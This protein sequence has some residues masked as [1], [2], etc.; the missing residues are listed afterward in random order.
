MPILGDIWQSVKIFLFVTAGGGVA[1]SIQL[2]E[3]RII[4]PQPITQDSRHSIT[5]PGLTFKQGKV[6]VTLGATEGL[7]SG[8]TTL[9]S[10]KNKTV[11]NN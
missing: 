2:E 1:I 10:R 5:W 7:K 6:V 9:E 8:R 3:A 4:A 11:G